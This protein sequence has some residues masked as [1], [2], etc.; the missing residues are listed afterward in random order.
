M[1]W[2]MHALTLSSI[3][4]PT[5]DLSW[6]ELLHA[7][8]QQTTKLTKLGNRQQY[9]LHWNVL[10]FSSFSHKQECINI[11]KCV[12]AGV[13]NIH[14]SGLSASNL[15]FDSIL[16]PFLSP[17]QAWL[18]WLAVSIRCPHSVRFTVLSNTYIGDNAH[19][20]CNFHLATAAALG[21]HK[22]DEMCCAIPYLCS[23]LMTLF[24]MVINLAKNCY[25]H[26]YL[27]SINTFLF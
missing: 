11:N 22:L 15:C 4:G 3:Y 16:P 17:R 5:V 26:L 9:C 18:S 2:H 6:L 20:Y 23:H 14:V 19:R 1:H 10:L 27:P 13:L 24:Y 8:R 7:R 21:D 12:G 25:F